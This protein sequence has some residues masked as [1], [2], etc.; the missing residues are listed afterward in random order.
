MSQE[1]INKPTPAANQPAEEYNFMDML[2]VAL[3]YWKW[4][5]ISILTCVLVAFLYVKTQQN[6]YQRETTV[7]IKADENAHS[8]LY[9]ESE[10]FSD[11]GLTG[12]AKKIDNELL[13]FQTKRLMEETARRLHLDVNYYG[14]SKFRDYTLYGETP[15]TI[16]FLDAKEYDFDLSLVMTPGKDDMVT[17]HDFVKGKT[18]Y[19]K[20]ITAKAGTTVQTPL[21][22]VQVEKNTSEEARQLKGVDIHVEKSSLKSVGNYYS[23]LLQVSAASK[24]SSIISLVIKDT[25]KKRAENILDTLVA[26]YNEDA[27]ND[28]NKV[29][30]N[31]DNFIND[32]LIT[33]EGE[34]GSVDMTIARF[35]SSNQL[36][37][38]AS[39]ASA[40]RSSYN[41]YDNQVADLQSKRSVAQYIL[42]YIRS[43][44]SRG[45]GRYEVIPNNAGLGN[46][47][48]EGLVSEYNTLTLQREKLQLDAGSNNPQ[49]LDLGNTIDRLRTRIVSS[50][51]NYVKGLDI[52]I[53]NANNRAGT[54]SSRITA[55]PGQQKTVTN[56][57][58][59]QRIK[60]N[61]Y[62]YLLNKREANNLK[63]NMTEANAR[64]LDPANGSEFPIAPRKLM[65]M[66]IGL[67]AGFAI[68]SAVIYLF[69]IANTKVRSRKDLKSLSIPF[70]GE[71][72]EV[73]D[74]SIKL[75]SKL[76]K[77]FGS[78]KKHRKERKIIVSKDSHDPVS[79]AVRIL[80][81][82]LQMLQAG[83]KDKKV[84]QLTSYIPSSG[85][86][87]VTSNLGMSLALAGKKVI[88]VDLDIR[89]ASLSSSV[90]KNLPGVT[91]YLGG[92]TDDIDSL[93]VRS[94]QSDNLDIL[95]AGVSAPNPAELL[96]LPALD[97]LVEHLKERYDYVILDT[98][99]FAAIADAVIVNRLSDI[100]MF[101]VRAGN[102]DRRMLPDV[103]ILQTEGKLKNLCLLLNGVSKAH[104]YSSYYGYG[105]HKYYGYG[106]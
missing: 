42:D 105:Y 68:P 82:N 57:E 81:T 93:I 46:T 50:L 36:T 86:T 94:K 27:I 95:P 67:I 25:S 35:K 85:K 83:D 19:N 53:G 74:N 49:V 99:P 7:L 23:K 41:S 75:F 18:R 28:K 77:I 104:L 39:D 22:R 79:E 63:R 17:L 15:V 12:F 64:V 58:R 76:G 31:T 73:E 34:L 71:I 70:V 100:T 37:D 4:Y 43:I 87:F 21:G 26:V 33:L 84:I 56:V 66:L 11:L 3:A 16:A 5:A 32:R 24:G 13:V 2:Y 65:I 97:K 20:E 45:E 92:Y 91:N 52:Q 60:E 72:P 8:S 62:M 55:V 102:L 98:V 59:Q 30:V 96:M 9:S 54:A 44:E 51:H 89:R 88:L 1:A 40:F 6:I 90:G 48:V 103:E 61:L 14:E 69:I 47:A 78:R 38:I 106:Y 80:R 10:A 101:I 29:V